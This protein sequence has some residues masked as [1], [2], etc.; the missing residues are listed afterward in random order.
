VAL[1]AAALK[2][3]RNVFCEGDVSRP[4]GRGLALSGRRGARAG[5]G[6]DNEP[7]Y[8]RDPPDV[9]PDILPDEPPNDAQTCDCH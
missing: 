6:G 8:S 3:R 4:R 2:D 1:L 9:L 5:D 7:G